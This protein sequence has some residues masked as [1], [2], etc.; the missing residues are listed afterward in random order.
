MNDQASIKIPT[1]Y[2]QTKKSRYHHKGTECRDLKPWK[3]SNSS[4][5]WV[6]YADRTCTADVVK[7]L[8]EGLIY[9][10]EVGQYPIDKRVQLLIGQTYEHIT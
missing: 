7:G 8:S 1:H 10:S 3:A 5:L 9:S 2:S 4:H 6:G